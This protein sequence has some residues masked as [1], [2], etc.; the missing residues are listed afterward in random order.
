MMRAIRKHATDFIAVIVLIV[1]AIGVSGFIIYN[2]DA[3]PAIPLLEPTPK[4]LNFEF[5]DAQAV[6]PG[7]G[8]SVRVAGV[9]V[10][11][12]TEV[13][14]KNGVAVVTT[15]IEPKWWDK[16]HVKTDATALLRPRTGLKDMF[17]ELDPGGK[18]QPVPDNGTIPVQ[19]TAP[20]ID[21]DEVLSAF[22]TDTRSYLQLLINGAGKGLKNRGNDLNA[23]FKALGPTERD[24]NRVTSAIAARRVALKELIHRYGDLTNTL[25][26]KDREIRTLVTSADAVFRAIGSQQGNVSLAVSRLP[27]ALRQTQKTLS[28]ANGYA[29]LLRPTLNSLRAPFRQLD[30]TNHQVLPFVREAYPITKNKIRPFVR[31]ARPVVRQ[32]RPAAVDLAR[33]TP[34]FTASFHEL[35][36]FFNMAAYNPGGAQGVTG[37][38]VADKARDEGYLYWASWLGE[39]TDSIFSTSDANGS[40][41]R[42]GLGFDCRTIKT[43]V[44]ANPAAGPLTGLSNALNDGAICGGQNSNNS[45]IPGL[46]PLPSLPPLP[47]L[48]QTQAAAAKAVTP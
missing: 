32:L 10:G 6:T 40:F 13:H 34:D 14:P 37:N 9:Q 39:L 18:G 20:D 35:N 41:R 7:Q 30:T 8:Q 42:V 26:D 27:G 45:I 36:R 2:Q 44:L 3:R 16:I 47:T 48:K 24:L 21:P 38:P 43:L 22:D 12:I 4:K 11:K 15:Q 23:I 1:I 5:S 31:T 19:N 25:A 33:A 17:I 29:Q 46:P 28:D